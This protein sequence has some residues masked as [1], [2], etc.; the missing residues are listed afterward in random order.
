MGKQDRPIHV[1]T[2]KKGQT[3]SEIRQDIFRSFPG[4]GP[5]LASELD[6]MQYPLINILNAIDKCQIKTL[7]P[8]KIKKVQ[9]VLNKC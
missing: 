2:H 7:G 1:N 9:E 6:K 3:I 4:I 8:K 5:K